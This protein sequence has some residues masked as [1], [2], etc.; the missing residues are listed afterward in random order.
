MGV[1]S[2]L[3]SLSAAPPNVHVIAAPDAADMQAASALRRALITDGRVQVGE[4]LHVAEPRTKIEPLEPLRALVDAA[5]Q[6]YAGLDP[7]TA[8][9]KVAE[10]RATLAGRIDEP[11]AVA[12]LARALRIQGLALLYSQKTEE[13]AAAFARAVRL[14]PDFTPGAQE[15]PPE[16]R[17]AYADAVAAVKHAEAGILSLRVEP[18]AATVWLDGKRIGVGSMTLTD[19]GAGEHFVLARCPGYEA[20]AAVV[21]VEKGGKLGEASLYLEPKSVERARVEQLAALP[22]AIDSDSE[23]ATVGFLAEQLAADALTYVASQGSSPPRALLFDAS[24]ARINGPVSLVDPNAA[25]V[26][27]IKRLIGEV[28][29]G[30]PLQPPPPEAELEIAWYQRWQ[31]W[32]IAGVA[33]VAA[34]TTITAVA[35]SKSNSSRIS[36]YWE[37]P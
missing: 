5:N 25:A 24:G 3:V 9:R 8:L 34:G 19:L 31:I 6:A 27:I 2:L 12:L 33:V 14:E 10:A 15:W 17:L 11:E 22:A 32:L 18:R 26:E 29:P 21:T 28:Q 16:A 36:L 13:A 35:I 7:R 4:I 20:V 23:K 37:R 1:L 30:V